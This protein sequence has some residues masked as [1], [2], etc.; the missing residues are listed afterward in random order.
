MNR[1]AL[2]VHDPVEFGGSEMAKRRVGPAPE[3]CGPEDAHPRRLP[4]VGA[5]H[6]AI[7]PLPASGAEHAVGGRQ[8]RCPAAKL[9]A[10]DDAMLLLD[11]LLAPMRWTGC[12]AGSLIRA[13]WS[14]MVGDRPCA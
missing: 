1:V 2:V 3:N 4:G 8:V 6:A 9:P 11:Q 10:C 7:Q 5:V 13:G 12:H 14:V